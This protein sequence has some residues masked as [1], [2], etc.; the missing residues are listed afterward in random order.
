M[1]MLDPMLITQALSNLLANAAQA[2]DKGGV[3]KLSA[4]LD[5]LDGR[6]ALALRVLDEGTGIPEAVL[7]NL[8]QPF[9]T[10]KQRG[11][12]LGLAISQNI[13]REHGGVIV[14][15]NRLDRRGAEISL[16]LPLDGPSDDAGSRSD[17][18]PA[19]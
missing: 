2:S 3:I 16:L 4:S 7:P 10:T 14:A 6:R 8:F 9:F 13:A 15:R 19:P 11:N 1:V 12:G 18:H 17:T 5:Y